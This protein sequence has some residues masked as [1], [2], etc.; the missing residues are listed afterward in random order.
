MCM[1]AEDH[2]ELTG[3]PRARNRKRNR[4]NNNNNNDDVINC[5][6]SSW[7]DWS[8][9][10]ATC[11]KSFKTRSRSVE[12]QPSDGGRK[13]PRKLTKRRRCEVE[14]CQRHAQTNVTAAIAITRLR[15]NLSNDGASCETGQWSAWSECSATCGVEA[16][17]RKT[18]SFLNEADIRN[19]EC[20]SVRLQ[21]TRAC[22]DLPVCCK[23]MITLWPL[24]TV[25]IALIISS[26]FQHRRVIV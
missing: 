23:F 3:P 20:E 16:V 14:R 4:Q 15:H 24:H 22:P 6:V 5:V 11:G 13:C 1:S 18:R 9:C 8:H 2:A 12:V 26:Y 17:Q 10:S 7:S 21:R 25:N 19:V